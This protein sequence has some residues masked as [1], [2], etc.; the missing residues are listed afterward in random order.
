L[1]VKQGWDCNYGTQDD[2]LEITHVIVA[3][4]G[5]TRSLKLLLIICKSVLQNCTTHKTLQV[6]ESVISFNGN[7]GKTFH[8]KKRE[9]QE[10][11]FRSLTKTLKLF[12]FTSGEGKN[13]IRDSF[14]TESLV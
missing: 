1:H 6:P 12:A 11:T 14:R 9:K 7:N 4:K 8:R 5:M 10:K 13:Y 2:V 3:E